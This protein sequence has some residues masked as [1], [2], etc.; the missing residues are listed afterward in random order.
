MPSF[1][2]RGIHVAKYKSENG[3]VSYSD[4]TPVGDA[5][6]VNLELK[7]AEGRLYAEGRLA[8]YI[9]LATGG[10][11]SVAVKYIPKDAQVMMYDAK[12][13]KRTVNSKEISGL[14]YT[15]KDIANYVGC[16]FYAP[17]KIDGVTK[18]TCVM[19]S[20]A[21]FGPPSLV[22]QTKGDSI[23]FNTPTTTGEFLG[24]D[25]DDEQ[26][27]ETAIVDDVKTAK[28]WCKAVFETEVSGNGGNAPENNPV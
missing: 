14:S 16:S 22:Y 6:N 15:T 24:D 11:L 5:M 25:S 10:T 28:A 12:E 23:T 27:F 8:E 18:Y 13:K 1:D 20:K 19:V 26:L 7:F 2:L 9:K 4:I 3:Q 17:D 21:L